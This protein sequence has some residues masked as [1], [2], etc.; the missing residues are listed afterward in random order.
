MAAM[1]SFK[2]GHLFASSLAN[3]HVNLVDSSLNKLSHIWNNYD[4]LKEKKSY[5]TT[6]DWHSWVSTLSKLAASSSS[7]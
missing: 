2:L 5:H 3:G 4:Y 7:P 1:G 6:L